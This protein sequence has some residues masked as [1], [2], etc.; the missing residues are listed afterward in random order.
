MKFI[1][2]IFI[3]FLLIGCGSGG[4]NNTSNNDSSNG[5]ASDGYIKNA[6]IIVDV[7]NNGIFGDNGDY[8]TTTNEY[9]K[10]TI[11]SKYRNYNIKL[12]GGIDTATGDKIDYL[13]FPKNAKK[14]NITPLTTFLSHIK[15][16]N[17]VAN[18]LNIDKNNLYNDP[19]NDPDTLKATLKLNSAKIL[20]N[21]DYV[22][23]AKFLK[24]NPSYDLTD[25]IY[26]LAESNNISIDLNV[27]RNIL[28][29]IDNLNNIDNPELLEKSINT[30]AKTIKETNTSVDIQ[31]IKDVMKFLDDNLSQY[32]QIEVELVKDVIVKK[33]KNKETINS[34]DIENNITN[35]HYIEFVKHELEKNVSKAKIADNVVNKIAPIFN[36]FGVGFGGSQAFKFH[37]NVWMDVYDLING[38]FNNYKDNITDFNSTAF[39]EVHQDINNSKFVE[40]WITKGWEKSW[41][42]LSSL[43]KLIDEGKIPVFIYFYFGDHLDNDY[44]KENKNDYFDDVQKVADYFGDLNGTTLFIF[45]PEFNKNSII[46]NPDEFIDTISKAIDILK[47]KMPNSL[48]SLCMTDTG[49]RD[50]N[51]NKECGYDNCALGDKDE[52]QKSFPIFKALANKLD[53]V[54]FQEMIAQFSRD[55]SNPGTWDDPNPISYSDDEIGINYFGKRVDNF[56]KFLKDN[57][58]KPVF[59]AYVMIASGSWDDANDD[60]DIQDDEVNASGWIDEMHT[61][62]SQLMDNTNNIFGFGV[63]NLFDDPNHDA[64]GYQF[65][66]QNEYHFGIITSTIKDKQLTG[67]IK[68]KDDLLGIIF[69][70]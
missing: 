67:D 29:D 28:L 15:D 4:E 50:V 17:K 3:L 41:Y 68:E 36:G 33:I 5:T 66:M 26:K 35:E 25:A 19:M 38:N 51:S 56:A 8:N 16:E 54:S 6:I 62:Y 14:L 24:N 63:M 65:F 57:L 49:V 12:I 61:G 46:E 32:P 31:I 37:D 22:S 69:K 13:L 18:I 34:V 55:P 45:E 44:L 64:G 27:I 60:G 9:G 42:N 58:H 7:N 70:K 43:Q 21:D 40:I 23:I 59:L 39:D 20:S 10:F 30:L 48:I 52:W 1:S 2:V 47:T 53:F 11:P